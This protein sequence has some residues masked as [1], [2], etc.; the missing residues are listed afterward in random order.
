RQIELIILSTFTSSR[1]M[2]RFVPSRG[3]FMGRPAPDDESAVPS[4]LVP[5]AAALVPNAPP[6]MDMCD[7]PMP[8]RAYAALEMP[9]LIATQRMQSLFMTRL[10]I[11]L[12]E[13]R[14]LGDADVRR[15]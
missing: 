3:P 6:V 8:P 10:L 11:S 7:D 15:W 5:G 14:N 12:S 9:I 4:E 2:A 13:L 1:S